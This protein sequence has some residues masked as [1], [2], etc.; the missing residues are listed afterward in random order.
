[1]HSVTAQNIEYEISNW[2]EGINELNI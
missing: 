1:M 2:Y